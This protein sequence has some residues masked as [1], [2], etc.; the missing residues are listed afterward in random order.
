MPTQPPLPPQ[1]TQK[2]CFVV[3]PIG[4]QKVA[5]KVV[6][7]KEKLKKY[8]DAFERAIRSVR[9]NM[10]VNRA[11]QVSHDTFIMTNI[12]NLIRH[13]DY[14]IADV[15]YPNPNVYYE[16]GFRHACQKPTIIIREEGASPVPFDIAGLQYI[17][18]ENC[19]DGVPDLAEELE[20]KFAYFESNPHLI[21]NDSQEM[22]KQKS[23]KFPGYSQPE[24]DALLNACEESGISALFPGRR[25]SE[26]AFR[27]AVDNAADNCSKNI[28]LLGV[29]FHSFFDADHVRDSKIKDR[30]ASP[31]VEL[32]ILL[33]N[34]NSEAA[35]RRNEIEHCGTVLC[36]INTSL[37]KS[38]PDLVNKR[39]CKRI[40]S[41]DSFK[42]K[43]ESAV[44]RGD[45]DLDKLI[46]DLKLQMDSAAKEG[47]NNLK[48]IITKLKL[49]VESA[50]KEGVFDL[51]SLVTEL[52]LRVRLYEHDPIMFMMRFDDS[53]FAEQYHFGRPPGL[54]DRICIGG[55][56]PIIQFA[57]KAEEK[58]TEAYKYLL[59]HFEYEWE[60]SKDVSHTVVLAGAK[61][62]ICHN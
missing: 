11:D 32:R 40:E 33:L 20:K 41:N 55:Y 17:E 15:T 52:K 12:Y 8:Y 49:Q 25:L 34:S 44:K 28:D 48:K 37:E 60:N 13:S 27:E 31:D 18:Y 10:I 19:F 16:L 35:R 43:V 30:L 46:T 61:E 24:A 26:I 42:N 6:I 29:C 21:D 7:K 38:I 1:P 53:L 36:N 47:V 14:V 58:D 4:D 62:W 5:N 54:I 51:D 3:M 9:P 39:I 50:A 2:T 59:A 57:K 56:V 23:R 45:D 22:V